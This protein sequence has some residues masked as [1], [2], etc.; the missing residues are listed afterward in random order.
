MLRAPNQPGLPAKEYYNDTEVVKSYKNVIGQVLEALLQEARPNSSF[1]FHWRDQSQRGPDLSI[2]NEALLESIVSFETKIAEASP[3]PEDAFDVTKYYNPRSLEET[4]ALIPQ[5]SIPYLISRRSPD[6]IPAKVIVGSPSYLK[7]VSK[8]LSS[9]KKETIQAYL[10]WK[11]VQFYGKYI[12]SEA[13]KPLKRFNN[14]LQGKDP[15]VSEERWRTCVKYVDGDTS[16]GGLGKIV[17]ASFMRS[18]SDLCR[19]DTQSI[20][21]RESFFQRC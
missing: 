15:D 10:V 20:L 4:R 14:Q 1:L 6:Y 9:A 2:T 12:E 13:L 21:R 8:L 19:L 17:G 16:S 11:T 18:F 3:D 5:I 7:A